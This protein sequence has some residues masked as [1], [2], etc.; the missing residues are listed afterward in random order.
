MD[1]PP[2]DVLGCPKR[3]R[4]IST[5]TPPDHIDEYL[6]DVHMELLRLTH[7]NVASDYREWTIFYPGTAV[8]RRPE[9]VG[10]L[11]SRHEEVRG[12]SN[13][14]RVCSTVSRVG[15]TVDELFR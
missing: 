8:C 3:T 4:W 5:V 13:R 2:C 9:G 10:A 1:A 14:G 12:R 11:S 6:C 7:P 15:A